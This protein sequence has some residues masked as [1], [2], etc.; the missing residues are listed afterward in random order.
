M[1]GPRPISYSAAATFVPFARGNIATRPSRNLPI[2]PLTKHP[3]FFCSSK[4]PYTYQKNGPPPPAPALGRNIRAPAP[5]DLVPD[6]RAAGAVLR[7]RLH[8]YS[9]HVPRG[10]H[11]VL[12]RPR[13]LM[14]GRQGGHD[15]GVGVGVSVGCRWRTL[16]VSVSL[17]CYPP[18][19][20]SGPEWWVGRVKA[21]WGN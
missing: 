1:P 4:I 7:R 2:S 13:L 15:A 11:E 6:P 18:L 5:Q 17:F 9:V 21:L 20:F 3:S 8:A 16:H 19:L 12:P 10:R 14:A